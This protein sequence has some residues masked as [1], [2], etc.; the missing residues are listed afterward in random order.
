MFEYT[1]VSLVYKI[2]NIYIITTSAREAH[3]KVKRYS[4]E[5][6]K[7]KN[8]RTKPKNNIKKE[9]YKLLKQDKRI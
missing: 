5:F 8:I 6:F 1:Y 4:L 9:I 7:K 2:I 3:I